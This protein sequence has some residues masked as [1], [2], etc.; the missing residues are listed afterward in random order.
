MRSRDNRK[1]VA[2]AEFAMAMALLLIPIMAGVWDISNFIDINQVVTRAAR[3]GIVMASRGDNPTET[4]KSYVESGGLSPENITV[5]ITM[6][7]EQ[8]GL[9]QEVKLVI[10]YNFDGY[11][12]LP[13]E[14]IEF[15]GISATAYAK[16]E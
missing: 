7:E 8:P 4:I 2:V 11:T 5:T 16:M 1:G 12:I 14:K 6:G 13:W 10:N 9:G 15:S 3:E